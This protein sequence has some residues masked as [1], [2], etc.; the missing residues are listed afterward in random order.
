MT[1]S[2]KLASIRRREMYCEIKG[3]FALLARVIAL[4]GLFFTNGSKPNQ[5]I[6]G[7]L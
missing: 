2:G 7:R 5:S 1:I 4:S 3:I 6:L